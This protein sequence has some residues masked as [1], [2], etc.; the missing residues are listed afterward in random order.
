MSNIDSNGSDS[1]KGTQTPQQV[2]TNQKPANTEPKLVPPRSI[3]TEQ[4]STSQDQT[5]QGGNHTA[6]SRVH[7]RK[8]AQAA[9]AE[10]IGPELL[11]EFGK[12]GGVA[13]GEKPAQH[14]AAQAD[15]QTAS[16]QGGSA[17]IVRQTPPVGATTAEEA[18][19]NVERHLPE[20]IPVVVPESESTPAPAEDDQIRLNR[21]TT[22]APEKRSE[23]LK[24]VVSSDVDFENDGKDSEEAVVLETSS[25]PKVEEEEEEE[26]FALVSIKEASKV[27]TNSYV[28]T[29]KNFNPNPD[30]IVIE[31]IQ[32]SNQD[33][34]KAYMES[35]NNLLSAPRAVRVPFLLSGYHADVSAF[36]HSDT[37]G[38]ARFLS[39][40]DYIQ[41]FEYIVNAV[42]E[43]ILTTSKGDI[44]F[45]EWIKVT[46]MP[47]LEA[48]FFGL[49]HATYPGLQDYVITCHSCRGQFPVEV[50]NDDLAYI[51]GKF[52]R[53]A[54]VKAIMSG[55][56]AAIKKTLVWKKA[57]PEK[58]IRF[59]TKDTKIL[60][61]FSIPT[62]EDYINTL[63]ALQA[64]GKFENVGNID[65][66]RSPEF[67][68][69]RVYPYISRVGFPVLR[70]S[71]E[72]GKKLV[73]YTGSYDRN[74]IVGTVN[75]LSSIAF[76]SIFEREDIVD[77]VNISSIK[78]AIKPLDCPHCKAKIRA[79]PINLQTTFFTRVRETSSLE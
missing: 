8:T 28:K 48:G 23:T 15:E 69:L 29:L 45:E 33:F 42:F 49:H 64:S 77:L 70:Q 68:F 79:V 10:K 41:R 63:R 24:Q 60:L 59:V 73:S 50:D 21:P 18:Q 5:A 14:P 1:T 57:N 37:T 44:T 54:D 52:I 76:D 39:L 65:D 26:P 3:K 58:P 47:D 6:N 35:R 32:E 56:D 75:N 53:E 55:N 78:Y 27:A 7:V 13:P 25:T 40:P 66:P 16:R 67:P 12:N 19:A 71:Q 36:S 51:S 17:K 20:S 34:Q 61:E 43:H 22:A 62:I 9:R 46:K 74:I 2:S 30:E 4:T 72:D 38:L 11:A 31:E